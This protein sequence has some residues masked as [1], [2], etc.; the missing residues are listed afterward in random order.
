MS[1]YGQF[2]TVMADDSFVVAALNQMGYEVEIQPHGAVLFGYMGEERPEKAHLI[3]RR[4]QL[5]SASNDIG[6]ARAPDGRIVAV[7][8]EY[9]RQI[10]YDN[11]WL[12]KVQQIYK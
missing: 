12:G 2:T 8:S 1:K 11:A 7:L 4:R 5:D 10:G 3:I 9:D 6:F